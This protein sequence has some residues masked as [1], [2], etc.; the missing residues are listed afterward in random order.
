MTHEER[1]EDLALGKAYFLEPNLMSHDCVHVVVRRSPFK[2]GGRWIATVY[3]CEGNMTFECGG[4]ADCAR[5]V[6]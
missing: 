6:H 5:S 3:C 2:A 4:L 1:L